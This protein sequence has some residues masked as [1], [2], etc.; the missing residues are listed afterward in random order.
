MRGFYVLLLVVLLLAV[1]V[2]SSA[3]AEN[4]TLDDTACADNCTVLEAQG[5]D[6]TGALTHNVTVDSEGVVLQARNYTCGPA[7]L[8]TVLQRLGVNTTEDELADLAGTTEEGTT[9]Q[10]LL[11]ASMAKGMNATGMKLNISELTENMIAYTINDGT[12][13]YTVINEITNDT[14]K[15]ADPSLGNIEMNIEEFAEIYSGYT[16]V[17]NDPNNPTQVNKTTDQ[18]NNQ[19]DQSNDGITTTAPV[20]NVTEVNSTNVR[21][22][23]KTLTNEE[24]QNINGKGVHRKK[25]RYHVDWPRTC[26]RFCG[27]CLIG[28]GIAT[29]DPI[30]ITSGLAL[31]ASAYAR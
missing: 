29:A 20:G 6:V 28:I 23:S 5:D 3:A 10:G 12:G 17:I 13:H 14:I 19:T 21:S 9:M 1:S 15:L 31:V 11:E 8:A 2:N 4:S 18:T 27:A 7:A 22:K 16:L 26:V 24:M 30:A 25:L